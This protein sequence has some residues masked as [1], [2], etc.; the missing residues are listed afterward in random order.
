MRSSVA[1][2]GEVVVLA[3]TVGT[4]SR[5]MPRATQPSSTAAP[6]RFLAHMGS[7]V[8]DTKTAFRSEPFMKRNAQRNLTHERN[9][10]QICTNQQKTKTT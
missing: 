2:S 1:C 4:E 7:S 10:T 8:G 6:R 5:A 3:P 9:V